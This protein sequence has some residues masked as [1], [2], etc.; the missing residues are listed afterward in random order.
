MVSPAEKSLKDPPTTLKEA[1]DWLALVGGGFGGN[2]CG[3]SGKYE[4][5]EKA[6]KSLD[7]FDNTFS[8][9]F[10][11]INLGGLIRALANGIG[12][13]FLGYYSNTH[14]NNEGIAQSR[15]QS[16]YKDASWPVSNDDPKECAMVFLGVVPFVFWGLGYLYFK[17]RI[18]NDGWSADQ[19]NVSGDSYSG[20]GA[21]MTNMGFT[22]FH[23]KSMKGS[24]VAQRLDS[25]HIYTFDELKKAYDFDST[26][27][28][29][30]YPKFIEK[31]EEKVSKT[32]TNTP[33]TTCFLLTK[34]YCQQLKQQGKQ[35]EEVLSKIKTTLQ[36]FETSF[37]YH[38][39]ELT[40][41]IGS[42]ISTHMSQPSSKGADSPSSTGAVAGTLTTLGL[43]SG[44]AAAYI[45][46]LGGAKTLV[47]GLLRIG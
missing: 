37:G 42:F 14:F 4:D 8:S 20:L 10:P 3:G 17:C 2:G 22:P 40:D 27:Y 29:S 9:N 24:A 5:L 38:N 1:L 30:S 26:Y 28:S 46:N 33:L 34:E 7:G 11:G 41:Q 23:L 6:L 25:G 18:P 16:T 44:A 47:N 15:Y 43:G 36:G 35:D 21:F 31:L 39:H 19:L 45:L 32:D 13:G 12:P